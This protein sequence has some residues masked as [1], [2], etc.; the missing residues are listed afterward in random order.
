[1]IIER[2]EVNEIEKINKWILIFGRRKTGKTYLVEKFLKYDEYYFIK[3]DKSIISKKDKKEIN[4]ETFKT[5]LERELP[6]NKTL[7]IDEFHRLGQE[8]LDL[9]Q[10]TNKNGKII[11]ISST[12]YLSKNLFS[13]KS[14]ILGFF[15]EFPL[16][17]ISLQDTLKKLKKHKIENKTLLELA[18][19]LREP[20][21]ID[22]FN[23]KEK[24]RDFFV[25][26][27]KY[28]IKTVPALIGEI[29]TEE[30]RS[31]SA[32]YEG[33]LRATANEKNIS[34]EIS[35]YLFK[36]K[37]IKKDDPSLIQQYLKNLMDFGIIKR[38]K[39]YGKNRLIYKHVSPLTK[40]FYYADEKYNISERKL[41]ENEIIRIIDEIMPMIV[42][43]NIREFLSEKYGLIENIIH[44]KDFELDG[45]LL[46]F[47]KPEIALEVKWRK[48]INIEKI[49][50]NLR[51]I[52]TKRKILF[53]IDKNK[54]KSKNKDIEII[55]INDLI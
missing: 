52:N 6:N 24:P 3:R 41:N 54:M 31:I 53:V 36:R 51:R 23:E 5:I 14:P 34:G 21:T 27:M 8:F 13:S 9:L 55:D 47:K 50:M 16:N 46:K 38:I 15:A 33:I 49:V 40:L 18:I 25:K 1:M 43:D 30:E 11:L 42:E 12:L 20:I 19:L 35:S 22:F 45:C 7:V 26:I 4:Y 39:V 28:N 29:F 48:D 44:E 32:I 10:Y 37:A 2:K 17:I